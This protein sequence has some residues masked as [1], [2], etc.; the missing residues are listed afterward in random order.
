MADS[1]SIVLR[2]LQPPDS[3]RLWKAAM[4]AERLAFY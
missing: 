4:E 3:D 2:D 1:N